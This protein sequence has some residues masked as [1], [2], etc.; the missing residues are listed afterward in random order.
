MKLETV[1]QYARLKLE[2]HVGSVLDKLHEHYTCSRT[3][4]RPSAGGFSPPRTIEAAPLERELWRPPQ[5]MPYAGANTALG[6][7]TAYVSSEDSGVRPRSACGRVCLET[8][9]SVRLDVTNGTDAHLPGDD[10]LPGFLCWAERHT[11][12]DQTVAYRLQVGLGAV[13]LRP[14]QAPAHGETLWQLLDKNEPPRQSKAEVV[15]VAASKY[16]VPQRRD[17]GLSGP[18]TDYQTRDE[19]GRKW[20]IEDSSMAFFAS[21]EFKV[22]RRYNDKLRKLPKTVL[23]PPYEAV[24][25]WS[26]NESDLALPL[27]LTAPL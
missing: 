21:L 8:S 2:P 26:D 14:A 11:L 4:T 17:H 18:W 13:W 22:Q 16:Y 27:T 15:L 20:V 7:Y 9:L 10:S 6:E 5:L 1:D 3:W 25:R 23:E 19:S 12:S 24:W